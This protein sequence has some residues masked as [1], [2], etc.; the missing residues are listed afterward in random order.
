VNEAKAPTIAVLPFDADGDEAGCREFARG[1]SED[2]ISELSRFRELHVIAASSSFQLEPFGRD[3]AR[4]GRELQAE[5][6]LEGRVRRGAGRVRITAQMIETASGDR[7]WTD[8]QDVEIGDVLEAQAAIAGRICGS[9]VPELEYSEQRRVER[10]RLEDLEAYEMAL[11]ACSCIAH[12]VATSDPARITEG[13]ALAEQAIGLDPLCARAHYAA[14]W[15]YLRRAAL[16]FFHPDGQSDLQHAYGAALRLRELD[17]GSHGAYAILGHIAMRRLQH[18]E[19]LTNLRHAHTLNPSDVVTLRWLSWVES[20]FG[21]A[22]EARRHAELSI[23][24]SPRDRNIDQSYWALGLAA[25]VA[26]DHEACTIHAREAVALNSSFHGHKVLLVA[27]CAEMGELEEARAV[28]ATIRAA[29]SGLLESRLEGK[30]YFAREDLVS[31]YQRALALAACV[32]PPR[33]PARTVPAATVRASDPAPLSQRERQ[34][35]SFVARGMSNLE[36]A[37]ELGL[38]EHTVKRHVANILTKL[39]LP[40]RASAVA[41]AARL[42]LLEFTPDAG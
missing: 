35:L 5:Y 3:S 27:C 32:P 16:A 20:N 1:I 33:A 31:R 9:L 38:S 11:Q 15:G 6:V 13:I 24:L 37:A 28:A 18:K 29:A 23:R 25:F 40:N 21:L 12:G 30:T 41:T 8:R 26:G 39:Q 22:D 36:I 2:I 14:A 10:R 4:P 17:R 7:F 34:I 19:A 42:G